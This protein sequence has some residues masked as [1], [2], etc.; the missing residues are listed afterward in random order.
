MIGEKIKFDRKPTFIFGKFSKPTF[1]NELEA[2]S[3]FHY[4]IN[5]R[6]VFNYK[7]AE[8]LENNIDFLNSQ[9]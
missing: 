3:R 6:I 1:Q 9:Q 4:V 7:L 2:E 5:V 8:F